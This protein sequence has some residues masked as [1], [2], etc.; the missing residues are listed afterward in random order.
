M[1][2]DK[3]KEGLGVQPHTSEVTGAQV[4]PAPGLERSEGL[5]L[6]IPTRSPGQGEITSTRPP[7]LP[8]ALPA[9]HLG[10]TPARLLGG[11]SHKGRCS[12]SMRL[13]PAFTRP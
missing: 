1:Q 12:L 13:P 11:L 5:P 8:P 6:L 3:I 2:R 4:T 9:L 10:P 7:L